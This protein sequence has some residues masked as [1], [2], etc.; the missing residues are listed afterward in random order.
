MPRPADV[1]GIAVGSGS[2]AGNG[3]SDETSITAPV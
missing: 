2:G 3:G 1:G